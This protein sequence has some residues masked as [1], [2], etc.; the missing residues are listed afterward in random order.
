MEPEK[1]V[2]LFDVAKAGLESARRVQIRSID[3][4]RAVLGRLRERPPGIV[5]LASPAG[6]ILQLGIGGQWACAQLLRGDGAPPYLCAKARTL[7]AP[8]DIEFELG[9]TPTPVAPAQCISF[10]DA[11]NIAEYFFK[12]GAKYPNI[13]W[14]EI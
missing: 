3:E 7:R 13:E 9:G 1:G 8:C 11:M 2:T 4:L 5:E 6:T 10:E 12:T 14:A